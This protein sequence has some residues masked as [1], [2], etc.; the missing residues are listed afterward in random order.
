M[1]GFVKSEFFMQGRSLSVFKHKKGTA[2]LE[3][4]FWGP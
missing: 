3:I 2:G 4:I 1:K